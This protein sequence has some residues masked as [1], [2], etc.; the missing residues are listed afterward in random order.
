MAKRIATTKES[1]DLLKTLLTEDQ[2]HRQRLASSLHSKK[3]NISAISVQISLVERDLKLGKVIDPDVLP[4]I[5]ELLKE[6][7]EELRPIH[8]EMSP[9]RVYLS[10]LS[11]PLSTYVNT[12]VDKFGLEVTFDC[13]NLEHLPMAKS[14]QA[15]IY[16]IC[17]EIMLFL[18]HTSSKKIV[19]TLGI[20]RNHLEVSIVGYPIRKGSKQRIELDKHLRLIKALLI[21]QDAKINELT[22]W[23]NIF[24]FR[25]MI[26]K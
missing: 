3:T 10:G 12:F 7:N 1:T 8:S 11:S 22:D 6:F 23:Q 4:G 25:F 15:G 20:K 13:P 2:E 19:I 21:W 18:Y 5:R 14:A 9:P 17:T 24:S 26:R 16:R